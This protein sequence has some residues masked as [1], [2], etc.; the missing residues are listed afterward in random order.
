[1]DE[2]KFQAGGLLHWGLV[3]GVCIGG[4]LHKVQAGGAAPHAVVSGGKGL[5][6]H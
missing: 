4:L 5:H 6:L 1:M 2:D 3:M